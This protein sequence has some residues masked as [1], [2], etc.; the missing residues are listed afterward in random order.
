MKLYLIIFVL[1]FILYITNTS[2]KKTCIEKFTHAVVNWD[3][4]GGEINQVSIGENGNI[5]AR[6]YRNQFF[7]Y[8]ADKKEWNNMNKSFKYLSIKDNNSIIGINSN[9]ESLEFSSNGGTMWEKLPDNGEGRIF[10]TVSIGNDNTIAGTTI[11]NSRIRNVYI[12]DGESKKWNLIGDKYMRQIDIR[13]KNEIW[14]ITFD[15]KINRWS[16]RSGWRELEGSAKHVSVGRDGTVW[17]INKEGEI[18]RLHDMGGWQLMKG[19][20]AK[21]ISVRDNNNI[22][23]IAENNK[24]YMG[25]VREFPSVPDPIETKFKITAYSEGLNAYNRIGDQNKNWETRVILNGR[26]LLGFTDEALKIP[27]KGFNVIG[28]TNTGDI[29]L[30][31]NYKTN[32]NVDDSNKLVSDVKDL[33]KDKS[34]NLVLFVVHYN[35]VGKISNGMYDYLT[36]LGASKIKNMKKNNSYIFAYDNVDKIPL[37]ESL[38]SKKINVFHSEGK[39]PVIDA[40]VDNIKKEEKYLF[41][42]DSSVHWNIIEKK[43]APN[44][45][46]DLKDWP[47]GLVEPFNRKIDASFNYKDSSIILTRNRLWILYDLKS[48][49]V[50]D[51]PNFIGEGI[52]PLRE[53]IVNEGI[54]AAIRVKDYVYMFVN[55][56]WIK[57]NSE[58]SQI[59]SNGIIG[60]GEWLGI[61]KPFADGID[62]IV[63]KEYSN[64]EFYL[65]SGDKW[66]LYNLDTREIVEGPD[67]LIYHPKFNR[68]PLSYRTGVVKP[69]QPFLNHTRFK[70]N[71]LSSY[72]IT[73]REGLGFPGWTQEL[74]GEFNYNFYE[75][76]INT[77]DYKTKVKSLADKSVNELLTHYHTVGRKD[78]KLDI[79][80]F[81]GNTISFSL[82]DKNQPS[83]EGYWLSTLETLICKKEHYIH[84]LFG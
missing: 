36:I 48:N 73:V 67:S 76:P 19:P 26:I 83:R 42:R 4:I 74:I 69:P 49:S 34:T 60:T 51:G 62:A 84:F 75:P 5:I 61:P 3:E 8:D 77:T 80:K 21:S 22:V 81:G 12:Y 29:K 38:E 66:L 20:K 64:K 78:K 6:S 54:N 39:Q 16:K 52:F 31:E 40:S 71:I 28:I 47:I 18:F 25:R 24:A 68:L 59:E 17:C 55:K 57:V 63:A 79:N 30:N 35:A 13:N 1:I 41:H 65:F 7:K 9:N 44:G 72:D 53:A 50:V 70:G 2:N 33:L 46:R 32:E 23:I 37:F 56:N 14:G 27:Q 58:L 82:L 15:Y 45:V 10:N 43:I 11:S